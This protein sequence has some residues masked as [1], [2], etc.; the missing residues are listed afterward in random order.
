MLVYQVTEMGTVWIIG[1]Y[2]ELIRLSEIQLIPF[3][4]LDDVSGILNILMTIPL[5]FLLPL[6]WKEFRSLKKVAFAG[7]LFSLAI[8]L[9]QLLNHRATTTDDLIM[10]TLGVVVGYLIFK[11]LYGVFRRYRKPQAE[12]KHRSPILRNE[13]VVYLICSFMGMFLFFGGLSL[14]H[15]NFGVSSGTVSVASNYTVGIVLEVNEDTLKIKK[16]DVWETA[17]GT[18]SATGDSSEEIIVAITEETIFEIWQSNT[19][20]TAPPVITQ[21][22]I[23]AISVGENINIY[24]SYEGENLV[25]DTIV[26]W[27]FDG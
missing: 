18:F 4:T 13:A 6:I 23:N 16:A 7:L 17:E 25:A 8:E 20:G 15:I 10:N 2:P 21:A 19:E 3:T 12:S 22:T 27:K 26:L 1:R 11:G 9:S 5:G 14:A 24:G